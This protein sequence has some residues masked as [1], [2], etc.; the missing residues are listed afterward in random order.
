[1]NPIF[2]TDSYKFS[3]ASGGMYPEGITGQYAYGEARSYGNSI[4]VFGGQMLAMKLA[5]NPVQSGDVDQAHYFCEKH[6]EPFDRTPW[7]IIVEEYGGHLPLRINAVPDGTVIPS[8]VPLYTVESTDERVSF[9]P[10]F[11]ETEIQRG[12]WYPTTIAS[13]DREVYSGLHERYLATGA[14]P[15]LLPFSLHDFAGRGVT[16]REQAEIGGAAHLVHFLGS[17]TVEGV[18]AANHYYKIDMSGFSVPATEHS[19]QTSWGPSAQVEYVSNV[20]LNHGKPGGIVSIVIDGYDTM[21]CVNILCSDPVRTQI[22]NSKSKVVFRPDSGDPAALI[23]KILKAQEK[24]FGYTTTYQGFKRINNVGIIWGDGID[25]RSLLTILDS[26]IHEGYAADCAVFGSG[27]ALLQ[28]VNRDTF[29]FAQKLSAVQRDG[30]WVPCNKVTLGK[31]SKGGRVSTLRYINALG[32]IAY[33]SYSKDEETPDWRNN[34]HDAMNTI[35]LNGQVLN[36]TD[37]VQ[38]RLRAL[39][40]L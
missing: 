17:D 8:R 7:D 15:G 13:L 38:V 3:H 12:F 36:Q 35:Y 16:C 26:I 4:V 10:S 34:E 14:D 29:K 32:Q 9:L 33:R 30:A 23:L 19:V 22:I 28:K 25:R 11:K 39:G 6:G 1:M 2:S 37:M 21:E 27:G 5:E 40:N 20:I 24:A 31:E 18:W